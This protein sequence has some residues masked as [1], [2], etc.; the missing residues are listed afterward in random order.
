MEKETLVDRAFKGTTRGLATAT[1]VATVPAA[2]IW[3]RL[4]YRNPQTGAPEGA[5]AV[6]K[7]RMLAKLLALRVVK[8]RRP[9]PRRVLRIA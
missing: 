7:E 4:N 8:R 9:I 3:E 1:K 2:H 6:L 5:V